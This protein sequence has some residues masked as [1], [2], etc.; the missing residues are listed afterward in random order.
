MRLFN[1]RKSP[2]VLKSPTLG[3]PTPS[4]GGSDEAEVI[5][6]LSVI[7]RESRL[8]TPKESRRR[9]EKSERTSSN[10]D[11]NHLGSLT[12]NIPHLK[13]HYQPET[14][15]TVQQSHRSTPHSAKPEQSPSSR[16]RTVPH[17]SSLM[18]PGSARQQ[19]SC[20]RSS[21]SW[22]QQSP[23]S[24]HVTSEY[25]LQEKMRQN[26]TNIDRKETLS[27]TVPSS[28]KRLSETSTR[29]QSKTHRRSS[30]G[31]NSKHPHMHQVPILDL[32][33]LSPSIADDR[34]T[35]QSQSGHSSIRQ[36][37]VSSDSHH[38]KVVN[39]T[40][41]TKHY[42]DVNHRKL[43]QRSL[44]L[45]TPP[46]NET[47]TKPSA[48]VSCSGCG[49]GIFLCQ[50]CLENKRIAQI[51][52]NLPVKKR[53]QGEVIDRKIIQ[54]VYVPLLM[55]PPST[56]YPTM[57]IMNGCFGTIGGARVFTTT[58]YYS[59]TGKIYPTSSFSSSFAAGL[60]IDTTHHS[61]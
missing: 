49:K 14:F 43:I 23:Q 48:A 44:R 51:K 19:N 28:T 16:N 53:E 8:A 41:H 22:Q 12:E 17:Q 42:H 20:R 35:K 61:S 46:Q 31:K 10:V 60:P 37:P 9:Y 7:M 59:H 54:P 55:P 5:S 24:C 57:P 27:F 4:A 40:C 50:E 45:S 25:S 18:V 2:S 1:H 29:V 56:A 26:E 13:I 34:K 58:N 11:F 15:E 3:I 32:A 36:T 30:S 47:T 52:D 6:P 38:P 21:V 39:H 33:Q